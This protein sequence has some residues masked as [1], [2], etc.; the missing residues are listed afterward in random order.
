MT[1]ALHD[2]IDALD[3]RTAASRIGVLSRT[4]HRLVSTG[5]LKS[6][7]LGRRRLV[8]VNTLRDY[9]DS[10]ETPPAHTA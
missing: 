1:E 2:S 5:E 7:K 3:I 4:M 6:I 9:L 8:R 10:L